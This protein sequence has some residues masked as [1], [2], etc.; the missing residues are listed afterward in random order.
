MQ[1]VAAYLNIGQRS[2]GRD[3]RTRVQAYDICSRDGGATRSASPPPF[4]TKTPSA[5]R[6][7]AVS[8]CNSRTPATPDFFTKAFVRVDERATPDRAGARPN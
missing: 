3:S 6:K 5:D 1:M 8:F 7:V 4:G 2:Y